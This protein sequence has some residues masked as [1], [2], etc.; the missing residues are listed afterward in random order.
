MTTT[1]T[2]RSVP[3]L[4][5]ATRIALALLILIACLLSA[6]TWLVYSN[7]WDE[8]EHLAAG[9]ELLDRG[10][11]EYD[12]EH[13][14]IVRALIALG[15]YL[16]GARSFGT[17]PPDGTQEGIDI[18]Y[19][20]GHYDLYLTLARLGTLPFLAVLLFAT[21]LW[22]R[23]LTA[24][25]GEAL[26][27]VL[28]L[29]CVPPVLGHAALATLDVPAA[30]T[31]LLALYA[32]QSWLYS[33]RWRDALF[34]G[35]TAGVAV[36]TKFSAIPFLVLGLVVLAVAHVVLRSGGGRPSTS[37]QS[38]TRW[39]PASESLG[40]E[41]S[42]AG[43]PCT[44]ALVAGLQGTESLAAATR[45][46]AGGLAVVALAALVPIL[47]AYGV[48]SSNAN[49]VLHRF[50]WAV[51]YLF[52]RHGLA[53]DAGALL[54][55]VWLPRAMKGF[56][57]GV[58]ALKAHNDTGHLSFL[59]GRVRA[60]GWWYFYLV[61]L[62]VKT[63]L[64]LLATGP[65]GL[66]MLARQGWRERDGWR[67]A[68]ALL[69]LTILA[70]A[71]LFSR[72]NIGIRHVLI[73]YPLLALGGAHAVVV[74]WRALRDTRHRSFAVLGTV[75]VVGLVGWQ[76]STLWRANPDYLP[77]F[78]EAVGHPEKVLVDSDLDWGQ[79]LWRLERRAAEIKVPSLSLAYRGTADLARE[80]LPPFTV[81]PPWHPTTGWIAISALAREHD[82]AG[83][84]WLSAFKPM[85]RIGK[86][87]DLYYVPPGR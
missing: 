1:P 7:T 18:L 28:L 58:V 67:L 63:P 76:V 77:Y 85:E 56:V 75:A 22:A 43:S 29:A 31:T 12:T 60:M 87:I 81:M 39:S 78:N 44:G 14:P 25:D 80:A 21:W 51:S 84:A 23:R 52:Q 71:S 11:Y 26:L 70:F 50:D 79:D 38:M 59:L 33:A 40:I 34:F 66:A 8:P 20:G 30:A 49:G 42:T 3:A 61:A 32:L 86:T 47:I 41:A 35:I 57:E 6:S 55:H 17:P 16:A 53:H 54:G 74:A 4:V 82:L 73:L 27:A 48:R 36:G 46:R 45:R 2:V 15:P 13:P 62:A 24:S 72:I 5:P 64:P 65:V 69:F 83:Y 68:P 19:T 37:G 9:I 10:K